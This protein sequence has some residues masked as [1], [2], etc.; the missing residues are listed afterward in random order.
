MTSNV[1]ILLAEDEPDDVFL[2]R[3]AFVKTR[4][5]VPLYTVSDG[6]EAVRYLAGEGA[7]ADR[8]RHPLPVLLLLDLKMPRRSGFEVL[9]WLRSQ[10][11]LRRLPVVVLTSSAQ[12]KDIDRAYD[13]G[14]NSYLTKPVAF[15]DL[16]T[17][18]KTLGVYWIVL[19]HLPQLDA[20]NEGETP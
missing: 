11:G 14:A 20:R 8:S 1:P 17:V 13:L 16:L 12:S 5:A 3:R 2:I 6:E 15:D 18:I 4:L 19:S 10:P 9:T 7:Y